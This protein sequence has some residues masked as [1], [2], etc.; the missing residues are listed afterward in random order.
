MSTIDGTGIKGCKTSEV[1][2][3]EQV[4]TS[5]KVYDTE[6]RMGSEGQHFQQSMVQPGMVANP[7][8]RGQLNWEK[9][10]FLW[11]LLTEFLPLSAAASTHN[12][13]PQ[14]GR[15]SRVYQAT[16]LRTDGVHHRESTGTGPVVLKVIPVTGATFSDFPVDQVLYASLFPHPPLVFSRHV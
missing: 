4:R 1:S 10:Y 3:P 14:S 11:C 13:Q 12:R 16:Q 15:Q 2:S 5:F 8:R 9:C 7:A 6:R